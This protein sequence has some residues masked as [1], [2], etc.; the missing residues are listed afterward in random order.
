VE[1]EGS[2]SLARFE[3]KL[4]GLPKAEV[5]IFYGAAVNQT[6]TDLQEGYG[7]ATFVGG[8]VKARVK[9]GY[10]EGHSV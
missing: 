7:Q 9:A 4:A 8:D 5:I 2:V 10:T 1:L 3:S 6:E